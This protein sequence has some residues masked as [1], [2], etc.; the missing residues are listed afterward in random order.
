MIDRD[1]TE[2]VQLPDG[3]IDLVKDLVP[4]VRGLLRR[5][6]SDEFQKACVR[7]GCFQSL[8]GGLKASLVGGLRID[9]HAVLKLG[10]AD[11]GLHRELMT[12]VN[13]VRPRT[14]PE[15]LDLVELGQGRKLLLMGNLRKHSTL[16][17][18]VYRDGLTDKDCESILHKVV[19]AL[20]AVRKT[21]EPGKSRWPGIP[22][23]T[24]PFTARLRS[25]LREVLKADPELK[26]ILALPGRVMGVPCPPVEELLN[27]TG[28]FMAER[29]PRVTPVLQHGDP[30]LAN[31]MARRYGKG[32][33]V[34]LIDPN[35]EVGFTDPL[36]DAG[37]L[38]H[39]AEPVGWAHVASEVCRAE[40]RA[41]RTGWELDARHEPPDAAAEQRRRKLVALL[42]ACLPRLVP[43]DSPAGLCHPLPL[44]IAAAHFGL[45]ALLKGDAQRTAW[46][47]VLA[48]TLRHL[49]EWQPA[50][51]HNR[52]V[53]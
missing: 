36:Y 21:G 26:P 42:K 17:D 49:G 34:T 12:A 16:L 38:F 32:Y 28:R 43:G 5:G 51:T 48:H 13:R 18:L 40:W 29:A 45:A 30:H 23:Q 44:A 50:V 41:C 22:T 20:L 24:D 4:A 14:F 25:K 1:A 7:V 2:D 11:L 3:T 53:K 9:V 52:S 35:P 8:G 19:E 15:I 37:K 47:F 39:W 46:R 31:I 27:R 10:G 6:L 33:A